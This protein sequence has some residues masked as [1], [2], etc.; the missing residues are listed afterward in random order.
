MIKKVVPLDSYFNRLSYGYDFTSGNNIL[1]EKF[2]V[3]V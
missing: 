1:D 3:K 2:M